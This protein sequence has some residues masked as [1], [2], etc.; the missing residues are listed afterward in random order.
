MIAHYQADKKKCQQRRKIPIFH[1][2][3]IIILHLQYTTQWESSTVES[4]YRQ[5]IIQ[6]LK[7]TKSSIKKLN[8]SGRRATV[9]AATE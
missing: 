7:I 5:K 6:Y 4:D 9:V 8:K 3:D 1:E 2:Q